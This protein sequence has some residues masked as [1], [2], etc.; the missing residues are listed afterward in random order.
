LRTKK[1]I[2][3]EFELEGSFAEGI[4][5]GTDSDPLENTVTTDDYTDARWSQEDDFW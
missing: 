5:P 4:S 3:H 2:E 1:S